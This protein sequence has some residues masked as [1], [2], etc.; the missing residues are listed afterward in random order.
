MSLRQVKTTLV[1]LSLLA[2]GGIAHAA[3]ESAAAGVG[4][5]VPAPTAIEVTQWQDERWFVPRSAEWLASTAELQRTLQQHCAGASVIPVR[6]AFRDL[7]E[8]WDRLAVMAV[9]PLHSGERVARTDP[10]LPN[11][12]QLEQAVARHAKPGAI[13]GETG[14]GLPVLE[15][16]LWSPPT[17]RRGQRVPSRSYEPAACRLAMDIAAQLQG[18][19]RAVAAEFRARA[20]APRNAEQAMVTLHELTLQ[21]LSGLDQTRER[22]ISAPLAQASEQRERHAELPR[23]LS[24]GA[25]AQRLARWV[26]LRALLVQ[27][28]AV[29]PQTERGRQVSIAA[30]LNGLGHADLAASLLAAA[31]AVDSALA[32]SLSNNPEALAAL[33]ERWAA[34]GTLVR[35]RVLPVMELPLAP[36]VEPSGE[37][38]AAAASETASASR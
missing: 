21:W 37:P 2:A 11:P 4:A 10:A 31:R 1:G 3:G 26:G 12:A 33:S 15:W 23:S 17:A 8:R 34:L 18:D 38:D 36:A 24:G 19:A 13:D 25:P 14:G 30:W 32:Q 16:L 6:Q 5:A 20:A 35:T 9:G 22:C 28:G 27:D 7:A 29:L